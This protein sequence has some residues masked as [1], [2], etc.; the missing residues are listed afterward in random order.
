MKQEQ[1]TLRWRRLAL[2]PLCLATGSLHAATDPLAPTA[3]WS[4]YS[5]GRASTPPLGWSSWN[6]FGTDID[7][8]KILGSAQRIVDIGLA[9]KGY[10]YINIDD[11]WWIR[12]QLSDGRL[13]IRADRFPSS[14][15]A[16]GSSFRPLTD[17]LHAMG[18]KAG[19]YPDLGRNTC[20]Q[21]YGAP[22]APAKGRCMPAGGARADSTPYGQT[23][24]IAQSSV[25]PLALPHDTNSPFSSR[26]PMID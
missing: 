10:R 13:Q 15:T 16:G 3:R 9:A 20:S 26:R 12:R 4:A 11:G 5:A 22:R 25:S 1:T 8:A 18:L 2:L 6:A 23:L 14:V 19:I 7:E 21:A 24:R 17:K